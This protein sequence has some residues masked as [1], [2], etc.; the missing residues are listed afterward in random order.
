MCCGFIYFSGF[1]SN[2]QADAVDFFPTAGKMREII[3]L[4]FCGVCWLQ[5]PCLAVYLASSEI[6]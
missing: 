4:L 3:Y 5:F 6:P 2:G 1:R